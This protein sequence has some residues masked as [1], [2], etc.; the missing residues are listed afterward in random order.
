MHILFEK[1]RRAAIIIGIFFFLFFWISATQTL[2]SDFGWYLR[3]GQIILAHGVSQTDPLS[4]TMSS[5]HY[6]EHEWLTT[7]FIAL[8]Y[9]IVGTAGLTVFFVL[10]TQGAFLLQYIYTKS[11]W[12]IL[13]LGLSMGAVVNYLG[14][15]AQVFSWMLFSLLIT[16]LLNERLWK[17][18]RFCLP[19]LIIV[20]VNL[21]GSFALGV[22]IVFLFVLARYL[23]NRKFVRTEW[24]VALLCLLASFINPYGAGIWWEVFMQMTD[25]LMHVAI[26]EWLPAFFVF[27]LDFLI[28]V[29][30]SFVLILRYRARFTW[31]E[32]L[33]YF[34]L[35]AIGVDGNRY[36]PYWLLLV[37]PLA[38][39]GMEFF[40]Q[41]ASSITYAVKRFLRAYALLTFWVMIILL[42]QFAQVV[43][44]HFY[45]P[46]VPYPDKAIRFLKEHPTQGNYFSEYVMGGY[47]DWKLPEKKVFIDGRMTTWRRNTA[48]ANESTNAFVDYDKILSADSGLQNELLKYH[49]DTLLLMRENDSE[50]AD[51]ID[52]LSPRLTD[53][54]KS[55]LE[56]HLQ[57][58][59]MKVVYQD[60]FYTIYRKQ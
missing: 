34:F 5:F 35:L 56:K 40:Y 16:V 26:N 4:Y 20:W 50:L 1:K 9:P 6:I 53:T 45:T 57:Q 18:F 2:D 15:R 51:F 49:I 30:L 12:A 58:L 48:P 32:L 21:H 29:V 28:L 22:V 47:L 44:S 23:Q 33:L 24:Y 46:Q 60:N 54:S 52:K 41:D 31:P 42:Y 36:I 59:G 8:L 17:R 11:Q 38:A 55:R 14:I 10:I 25:G 7:V 3:M 27:N 19:L 39:K 43:M 37:I 13:M